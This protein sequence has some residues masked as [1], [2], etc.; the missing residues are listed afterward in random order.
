MVNLFQL[1]SATDTDL[2]LARA[3]MLTGADTVCI[4]S[5]PRHHEKI[6]ASS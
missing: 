1:V 5:L 4:D 2:N 6:G 3:H